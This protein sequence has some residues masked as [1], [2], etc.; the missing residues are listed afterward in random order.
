MHELQYDN[1]NLMGIVCDFN[2]LCFQQK[3]T[4]N[5]SKEWNSILRKNNIITFKG[6]RVNRMA[7][8]LK[9]EVN[10]C[11]AKA[12]RIAPRLCASAV[13]NPKFQ[14]SPFSDKGWPV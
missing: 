10:R 5:P 9:S 11:R 13:S 2:Y 1:I 14:I 3:P 8:S 6:C 7:S 12:A 4:P